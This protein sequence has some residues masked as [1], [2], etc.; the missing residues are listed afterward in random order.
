MATIQKNDVLGA[1]TVYL[2]NN[3][4]PCP[5]HYLTDKFGDDVVEVIA[6]LK[7]DGSIIGKR[8][9]TG[10][11]A[12]PDSVFP[13]KGETVTSAIE[14]TPIEIESDSSDMTDEDTDDSDMS[15]DA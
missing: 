6:D 1:I 3:N 8:G 7:K 11:I 12:F 9:R 5:A 4:R 15:A 10:G 13:K 14:A 2:K